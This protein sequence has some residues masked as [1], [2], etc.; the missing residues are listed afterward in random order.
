MSK[1]TTEFTPEAVQEALL[2]LS[3]QGVEPSLVARL[4]WPAHWGLRL[5]ARDDTGSTSLGGP[6]QVQRIEGGA[7]ASF[8]ADIPNAVTADLVLVSDTGSG[9]PVV[10]ARADSQVLTAGA[11]RVEWTITV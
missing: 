11:L 2:Q 7:L 3:T 8:G 9:A 10:V 4:G 1:T 6:L 5:E